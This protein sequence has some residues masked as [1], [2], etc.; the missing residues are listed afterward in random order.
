M[1]THRPDSASVG[2]GY[3]YQYVQGLIDGVPDFA[4]VHAAVELRVFDVL[5]LSPVTGSMLADVCGADREAMGRLL[6]WLHSRGFVTNS[7]AGG[8][9]LTELGQVLTADA[10]PSQRHAVLVTGSGYW[11]QTI[12]SLADVIRYGRPM[13]PDGLAPVYEHLAVDDELGTEFDQFMTARSSVVGVDLAGVDDWAGVRVVA[14]LGGGCGG[15]LATLLH[16]HPHLRGV[17]AERREVT[18]RART[19][20]A[21]A[22]VIDRVDIVPADIF[23]KLPRGAER[24]ILSSVL[25]NYSDEACVGLLADVR[26]ALDGN[27][28]QVWIV[29][30]MVPDTPGVPSRWYSTDMRMMALFAGGRVRPVSQVQVLVGQAG[31]RVRHVQELPS[32]HTLVVAQLRGDEEEHCALGEG[33][34]LKPE[35]EPLRVVG[36]RRTSS[37]TTGGWS[38]PDQLGGCGGGGVGSDGRSRLRPL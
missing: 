14:D 38:R 25:H 26:E 6:A 22:G 33:G 28:G 2:H 32:G 30:G 13:P 4:A 35:Q 19:Y 37:G 11:W 24:Y 7:G 20:L 21:G 23:E 10:S 31:L 8:Y 27:G 5:A 36:G 1:T 15:V 18:L 12:G 29:E 9:R 16:A 17:L 34:H 3:A